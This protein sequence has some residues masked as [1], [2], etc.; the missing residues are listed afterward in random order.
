[1]SPAQPAVWT[2]G[3]DG[4]TAGIYVFELDATRTNARLVTLIPL[5]ETPTNCTFGGTERDPLDITSDATLF[6][7]RTAVQGR[8]TPPG[9]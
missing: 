6:R 1:M 9:K 7:I 2:A 8:P 4:P 3:G 5:P